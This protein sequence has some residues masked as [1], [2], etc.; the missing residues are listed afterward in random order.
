V[1]KLVPL[2]VALASC[3]A[4]SA[5]AQNKP[6]DD[7]DTLREQGYFV[8]TISPIFSQLVM[9][10]FPKGFE[11]VFENT[12]GNRYTREAVLKGETVDRWTQM[13]TVTGA[14]GLA[15]NPKLSPQSLA[16]QIATGFKG[17]CPDTFSAGEVGDF[18]IG[19]RDAFI[20]W[21][22]CGTVDADE[23]KH[24]ESALLIALKGTVD[25]YTIQ[26]A[27]RDAASSQPI[28]FNEEKWIDRLYKLSPIRLCALVPREAPPYP[29]CFNR[30]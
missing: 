26:W 14:K 22:S 3:I 28:V 7:I 29:S 23:P 2:S 10:S 1:H 16:E 15:A 27:E 20:V 30:K 5:V 6:K 17:A 8:T 11:T 12:N 18:K 13:I 4:S 25:Y 21:A 19:G 24:S 9:L